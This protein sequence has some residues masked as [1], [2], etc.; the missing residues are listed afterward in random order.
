M[1]LC[2]PPW[3][4]VDYCAFYGCPFTREP[5]SEFSLTAVPTG[6]GLR[7]SSAAQSVMD[8]S[9]HVPTDQFFLTRTGAFRFGKPSC[10]IPE[11]Q[12]AARLRD[13]A[14][15]VHGCQRWPLFSSDGRDAAAAGYRLAARRDAGERTKAETLRAQ[16]V[17]FYS[18][19]RGVGVGNTKQMTGLPAMSK[20]LAVE[21]S[22]RHVSASRS[23]ETQFTSDTQ[24]SRPEPSVNPGGH[25]ETPV[26]AMVSAQVSQ[27]HRGGAGPMRV[28]PLTHSRGG[29]GLADNCRAGSSHG[30]S[31]TLYRSKN[32]NLGWRGNM[33]NAGVATSPREAFAVAA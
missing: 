6:K 7:A 3:P 14:H 8:L 30:E 33:A 32:P 22:A 15:S 19:E 11:R 26:I 25:L 31:D 9:C 2:T 20:R 24:R 29:V 12:P 23:Q 5:Q 18:C 10:R 4:H 27:R 28:R 13:S 21:T 17:R 1:T 16:P